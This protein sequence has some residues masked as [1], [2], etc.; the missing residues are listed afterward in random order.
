MLKRRPAIDYAGVKVGKVTFT[1]RI[2]EPG[3]PRPVWAGTCECGNPVQFDSHYINKHGSILKCR[4][5][6]R[7]ACRERRGTYRPERDEEIMQ[8][9]HSNESMRG[10]AARFGI[11]YQRVQKIIKLRK[12]E[13]SRVATSA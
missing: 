10:I 7:N 1:E 6:Y 8:L 5:C 4:E 13:A 2:I 11:S 9:H 12:Q 3:Q